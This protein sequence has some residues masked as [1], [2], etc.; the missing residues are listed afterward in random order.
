MMTLKCSRESD[1]YKFS[2]YS[3]TAGLCLSL[4]KLRTCISNF[5]LS[6]GQRSHFL[7]EKKIIRSKWPN[8]GKWRIVEDSV[9]KRKKPFNCV[10]KRFDLDR[11]V[12]RF[13]TNHRNRR[14]LRET[15]ERSFSK[16]SQIT[17]KITSVFLIP[18]IVFC[19]RNLCISS[20]KLLQRVQIM[21]QRLATRS[22]K[23]LIWLSKRV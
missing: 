10:K 8:F 11:N 5:Q 13:S 17:H 14:F 6:A 19:V 23:V 4:E 18:K 20:W 7:W 2:G 21:F 1:Q 15:S 12:I 9:K 22:V 3:I 16:Y